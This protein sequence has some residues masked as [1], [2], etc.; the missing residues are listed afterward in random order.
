LDQAAGLF[1]ASFVRAAVTPL[2]DAPEIAS[3]LVV[4]RFAPQPLSNL[5]RFYFCGV[6]PLLFVGA[7]MQVAVVDA[8]EGYSEF[9]ADLAANARGCPNPM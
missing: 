2:F 1:P 9:V 4:S 7:A 6:P 5:H 8:A 3:P